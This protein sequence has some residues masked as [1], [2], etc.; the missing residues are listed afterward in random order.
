MSVV[1]TGASGLF[2]RATVAGLLK[3]MPAGEIIAM[4][5]QPAKLADMAAKGVDGR[6][7]DFNDPASLER[8]FAGTQKMLLIS[9][10]LVGK[11]VPQHRNAIEAAAAAGIKQVVYTSYVGKG[12]EQNASL[13]VCDHRGT[14]KLLRESGMGWTVLR[15]TQYTEAV[16]EAQAP[17]AL[18]TGRWIACAGEGRMAQVTREDCVACAIAVLTTPGHE[19]I[20]YNITGSELMSFRDIAAIISDIAERPIEYVVVDDEGMYAFFDSLGI[21]RDASKEEVVNGIPWSSDDMVSV[22]RAIRLGQM[23]ILTDHVLQLTGRPPK[24]LHE[25]AWARRDDLRTS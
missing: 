2:G 25:L 3:Q 13:A 11:R 14:E 7:G 1:V 22:E 15:N 17:H 10:S 24:S 21:P 18:R 12:D 8:A 20:V 4:T 6:Q 9:A 16:I 5:R 23:E 19:D